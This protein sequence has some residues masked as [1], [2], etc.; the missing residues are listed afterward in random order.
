[1]SYVYGLGLDDFAIGD[2]VELHPATNLWFRGARYGTVRKVGR[3]LITVHVDRI[4][5]EKSFPPQSLRIMESA[6]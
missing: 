5:G 2:R 4:D 1:M 6:V 3:K